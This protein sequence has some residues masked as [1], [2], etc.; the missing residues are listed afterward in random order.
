MKMQNEAIT[1]GGFRVV[2]RI[3]SGAQGFVC[4]ALCAEGAVL[5]VGDVSRTIAA[6]TS[7]ALKITKIPLPDDDPEFED[8]KA[9]N[10]LSRRIGGLMRLDHPSIVRYYGAFSEI[11][12][13]GGVDGRCRV[14]VVVMELLRGSTLE[15][16][17]GRERHGLDADEALSVAK[18]A[19]SGLDYACRHGVVH[20]D[21]KPANLFI[22]EDGSVRII[23]F[24]L[25]AQDNLTQS[26]DAGGLKGTLKYMSPDFLDADFGGDETSDVFSFGVTLHELLTGELPFEKLF[27]ESGEETLTT[28]FASW[29]AVRNGGKSPVRVFPVIEKTLKGMV[30]IVERALAVSRDSRFA[31]FAEIAK[32]LDRVAYLELHHAE[33]TY[34]YLKRVGGGGFG[35]VYK[36]LDV[37]TDEV[38]AIKRL[39][40]MSYAARFEREAQ[41]MKRLQDRDGCFVRLVDY[42]TCGEGGGEAN[43][44]LVMEYLEG[45]P[46]N[47]LN[48]AIATARKDGERLDKLALLLVFERYARGLAIMHAQGI[49]HRDIKPANLYYAEGRPE[50]AKIM[51]YGIVRDAANLSCVPGAEPTD[52][53][54]CTLEYAPPE[55]VLNASDRGTAAMDIYA[56][57]LSLYEALTG[58]Q[59]FKPLP[60][61]GQV[62]RYTAFMMR[63][64]SRV[65]PSFAELDVKCDEALLAL[66]REMTRFE[67][68][69]RLDDAGIVALRLRKL[70]SSYEMVSSAAGDT[71]LRDVTVALTRE[72]AERIWRKFHPE[73]VPNPVPVRKQAKILTPEE[74]ESR[75]RRELRRKIFRGLGWVFAFLVTL[76]A[77]VR[78]TPSLWNP[79]CETVEL[80]RNPKKNVLVPSSGP[81]TN[82][83]PLPQPVVVRG[84]VRLAADLPPDV[85]CLFDDA[86]LT[87]L[88]QEVFLGRH[89]LRYVREGYEDQA[90]NLVLTDERPDVMLPQP[91]S[92]A[93]HVVSVEVKL[94]EGLA[95]DVSCLFRGEVLTGS[96]MVAPGVHKALY[97]RPGCREQELTFRVGYRERTYT[98]P[99]PREWSPLPIG[100]RVPPLDADVTCTLAGRSVAG[101]SAIDLEPGVYR[102][103]YARKFHVG[104][105]GTIRIDVGDGPKTLPPPDAWKPEPVEVRVPSLE[106]DVTCTVCGERCAGGATLR[107]APGDIEWE[108]S[109]NGYFTKSG[110]FTLKLGQPFS[111]P[112]PDGRW[113][114]KPINVIVPPLENG[115]W[116]RIDGGFVNGSKL[117]LPGTY[118]VEYGKD[119]YE[120]QTNSFTLAIGNGDHALKPP[121][122]WQKVSSVERP[123]CVKDAIDFYEYARDSNSSEDWAAVPPPFVE[124]LE[125]GYVL[126]L[127][128]RRMAFEAMTRWGRDLS[129][130]EAANST[131]IRLD[132]SPAWDPADLARKRATFN[133]CARKLGWKPG[134]RQ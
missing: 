26:T 59:A 134:R 70:I 65:E 126:T 32:E 4:E 121:S 16:R 55:I 12:D 27:G 101:G 102:W 54:P 45:M 57:G 1:C 58:A 81:L 50:N 25:A 118:L 66:L 90:F 108:Y 122:A 30:A 39:S 107:F 79:I 129:E 42:F 120:L 67:P 99:F 29:T 10:R 56:L 14:H 74:V 47:A 8:A 20:R 117:L 78:L 132:R 77:V 115:V 85:T 86:P 63:V 15:A 13:L 40:N 37:A 5:T 98:L 11:A 133:E 76:C 43:A 127:E 28:W 62:Q 52:A 23:D 68:D 48:E 71:S 72:D 93:W 38:V 96:A 110:R 91:D 89:D 94:P 46:G 95:A 103:A 34:R 83:I 17:L 104:Q 128:E 53:T 22:C 106:A 3:G 73:T 130:K 92:N 116:C 61:K 124:G 113:T 114:V 49:V 105:T 51:D 60:A 6:G 19:A 35:E 69:Q 109:R 31:S 88:S 36:G 84:M 112:P 41:T 7:V 100:V 24:G 75:I 111:L 64:N 18:F 123:T 119:G 97:R 131:A 33:R 44:Y 21:I 80:V 125:L 87:N 82:S 2:R 9:W